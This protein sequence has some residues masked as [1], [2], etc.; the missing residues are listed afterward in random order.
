MTELVTEPRR[1]SDVDDWEFYE[2]VSSGGGAPVIVSLR[3]LSEFRQVEYEVWDESSTEPRQKG[4]V[5]CEDTGER[6]PLVPRAEVIRRIL[7][8]APVDR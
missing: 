6:W 5:P 8:D 2:V 7:E 1:L 4:S 3:P